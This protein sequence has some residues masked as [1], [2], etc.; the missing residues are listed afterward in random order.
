MQQLKTIV[1][2]LSANPPTKNHLIF[3][4]YLL[5]LTSYDLV[6]VVLSAQ[7]PLKSAADYLPAEDRFSLL[8]A[9]LEAA[10]IDFKRCV[11]ERLE[12][13]RPPPSYM[14]DTLKA[15]HLRAEQTG[16]HEHMTL[17]LGLD[18]LGQFTDWYQWDA[19]GDVCDIK[20]YPRAGE[21]MLPQA[22]EE[23]LNIL[24]NAGIQ[25]DFIDNQDLPMGAGS[26][27]DARM[28]YAAG[29]LGIPDGMTPEVDQIIREHGYYGAMS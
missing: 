12:L 13:E 26:A 22:I 19:Y 23:Q 25:A 20:F 15:L 24:Q 2:G 4:E 7:S 14:I 1:F 29:K 16:V 9:M 11:L 6:R 27:T 18:A 5:G 8:K 17:V 21:Q 28:H 3:I 10:S